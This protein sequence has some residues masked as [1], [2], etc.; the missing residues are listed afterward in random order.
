V[1]R[2]FLLATLK[3]DTM[4]LS[5]VFGLTLTFS[6][7][8]VISIRRALGET[9]HCKW[10]AGGSP[11]CHL[12]CVVVAVVNGEWT[13]VYRSAEVHGCDGSRGHQKMERGS[14]RR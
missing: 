9:Y 6:I 4:V 14:E 1:M 7:F 2:T 12:F 8:G 10:R 5:L 13:F 3:R 11:L